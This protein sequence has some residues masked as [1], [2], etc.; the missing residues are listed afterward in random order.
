[1]RRGDMV[2]LPGFG[3][4]EGDF[5][6]SAFVV[7]LRSFYV[8]MGLLSGWHRKRDFTWVS[9]GIN[10]FSRYVGY[11]PHGAWVHRDLLAE[12]RSKLPPECGH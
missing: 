12:D 4:M 5:K 3:L 10:R 1:M 7:R 6:T 8:R 9:D 2:I 11:G